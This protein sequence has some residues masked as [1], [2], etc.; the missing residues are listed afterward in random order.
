[1][2]SMPRRSASRPLASLPRDWRRRTAR[3]S[4]GAATVAVTAH[5]AARRF[6]R[7]TVDRPARRSRHCR[8]D[9]RDSVLPV[10]SGH[11][12]GR[13]ADHH[14][15]AERLRHDHA[16]PGGQHPAARRSGRRRAAPA[17]QTVRQAG[18]P[19]GRQPGVAPRAV[20]RDGDVIAAC[21]QVEQCAQ[22]LGPAARGRAQH[23]VER[24]TAD[25]CADELSVAMPAHKHMRAGTRGA[26]L[27]ARRASSQSIGISDSRSCQNA[28]TTRCARCM[29][30]HVL[31][32]LQRPACGAQREPEI[33][34]KHTGECRLS[35]R[36]LDQ[37]FHHR[38]GSTRRRGGGR[39][40]GAG[41]ARS[42]SVDFEVPG[43][44]L[45]HRPF[46][47]VLHFRALVPQ[48]GF[49]EHRPEP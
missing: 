8:T 15:T 23:H 33:Q 20:R 22:T 38:A 40:R 47:H 41:R 25:H 10:A 3:R 31:M 11:C 49:E 2:R 28:T 29:R 1:M 12:D 46:G 14:A 4:P 7:G 37:P 42:G 32:P 9:R 39:D 17:R 27:G 5:K 43:A 13:Q 44:Q 6:R 24:E 35:D 21:Q 19:Q 26:S 45:V 48:V 30:G 36:V 34:P 16:V 18:P